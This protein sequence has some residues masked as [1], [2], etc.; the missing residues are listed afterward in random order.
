MSAAL[1]LKLRARA[2]FFEE[3]ARHPSIPARHVLAY[4]REQTGC[5]IEQFLCRHAWS[6]TGTEYG[7][8]DESYRGEGRCYCRLCGMEGDA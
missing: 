1:A 6:Y 8:D 2:E 3:R 5:S 4:L 7:G